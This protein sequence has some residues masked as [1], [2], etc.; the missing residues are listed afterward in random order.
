MNRT[1][2]ALAV[3]AA[4]ATPLAAQAAPTVYGLL[5][6]SVDMVDVDNGFTGVDDSEIQ[7][8]SNSSRLGVKGEEDLGNGYSAVY[9]AE[10]SVAGDVAGI[11][12]LVGRDRFLGLKSSWGTVKLGAYDSPF[13]SSQGMVDQFNDMTFTD[14][15]NF[16]SGENRLDNVIGYESPK[17]A[18]VL[19]V[20]VAL[21]SGEGTAGGDDDAVSLSVVFESAGLYLAAAIDN[22]VSADAFT[23]N[24]YDTY[25]N[26]GAATADDLS[27]D[28]LRLTAVY[29]IDNLQLGAL[30]QTSKYSDENRVGTF[31]G[32]NSTSLDEQTF[33][34]SAAYTAGK[35]VLK[36]QVIMAQLDAD[37]KYGAGLMDSYESKQTTIML[38][39][40]HNFTSQT[41]A[42]AQAAV[43]K[44]E[45]TDVSFP[46]GSFDIDASVISVGMQ[47]KF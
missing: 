3:T 30:I 14:M 15:Q 29:T 40:D 42:F 11:N 17:I 39:V 41:K 44:Q 4:L 2:L 34:L 23:F 20:N 28:A 46:A 24:I 16:M 6:L 31:W 12:D 47:T 27:R 22:N 19:T 7:V 21:Q 33:L 37:D 26:P 43:T 38:G 8:N 9:K 36:G 18:D 35:S 5:N 25:L 45:F 13:K 10:W 1:L 32:S